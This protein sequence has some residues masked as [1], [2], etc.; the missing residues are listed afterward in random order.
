MSLLPTAAFGMAVR[1]GLA[2]GAEASARIDVPLSVQ[3][4]AFLSGAPLGIRPPVPGAR[5]LM[6]HGAVA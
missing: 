4:R 1:A 5:L 6:S 2:N 3:A